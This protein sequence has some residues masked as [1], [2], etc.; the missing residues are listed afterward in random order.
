MKMNENYSDLIAYVSANNGVIRPASIEQIHAAEE[1]LGL[2]FGDAYRTYL[3]TFG[4]IVVGS[5]E[6]FG[7]GV[8]EDYY[9]SLFTA[10]ADLASDPAYPVA[11]LPLIDEGDGRYHLYDTVSGD[12]VLWATPNGGI[13][14][15][16][17]TPLS[18]FLTERVQSA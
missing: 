13:V 5:V 15:R 10:Y 3:Q 12:I 4:V 11:S 17:N 14:H 2:D 1:H 8:P 7:L 18:A 6:V 9:L 16:M